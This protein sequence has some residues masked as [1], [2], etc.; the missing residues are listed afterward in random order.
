ME[1]DR[2]HPGFRDSAYRE[3]RDGIARAAIDH[4]GGPPPQVDY[5]PEE[6]GVW[7]EIWRHLSPLHERLAPRGYRSLC[8]RLGF[9][10]DRIPQ[11]EGV[12]R[13]LLPA[14]GF[15][16]QPVAGLI[17]AG[18][19]LSQLGDGVFL[20]TQYVRH[21]STPL[22]TPEPD[23]V[24]ELVGH[25]ASF[26]HP[27]IADLNR[28]LGKAAQT[29]SADVPLQLERVYWWTMEFGALVEE[30]SP[31]AFGAGLLSSFGEIRR[32]EEGAEL[33]D[34]NVEEMA[35]RDYDPTDYQPALFVA[36]SWEEFDGNLRA[37]LEKV[38]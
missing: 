30:G 28:Q 4:Q 35:F 31:R 8:A 12:N 7:R 24:H 25:A 21:P 22:Y 17:E 3:R 14:T 29:A 27:G 34:F 38:V 16:M 15:Q 20:A 19:F 23:V 13:R 11:M 32:L 9:E 6:N 1:L 2:D 33:L 37:W 10:P 36:S 5:T 26:L 18:A